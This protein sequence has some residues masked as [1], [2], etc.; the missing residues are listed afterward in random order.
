M[1]ILCTS[2]YR[3]MNW[4]VCNAVKAADWECL[5]AY[6]TGKIQPVHCTFSAPGTRVDVVISLQQV[7]LVYAHVGSCHMTV[8]VQGTLY[9]GDETIKQAARDGL[10][11]GLSNSH[12][13]VRYL[14]SSS[15]QALE[16][17]L[18]CSI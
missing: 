5:D 4:A 15:I 6:L 13:L 3:Q 2:T 7:A 16:N 1:N 14:Q 18:R 17:R 11:H 9:T 12:C 10:L 8:H